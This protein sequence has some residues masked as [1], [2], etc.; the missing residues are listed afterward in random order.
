MS[1]DIEIKW[2][3]AITEEDIVIIES[4]IMAKDI[5]LVNG[6]IIEDALEEEESDIEDA[7]GETTYV[8]LSDKDT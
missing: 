6:F 8:K 5:E 1:G 4:N 3:V 2:N 7:S